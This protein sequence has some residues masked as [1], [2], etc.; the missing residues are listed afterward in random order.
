MKKDK[1]KGKNARQ[2]VAEPEPVPVE[3][4]EDGTP[5]DVWDFW[6]AKKSPR[7]SLS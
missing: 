7:Q 6:G 5:K 4:D 2:L 1:K 3:V